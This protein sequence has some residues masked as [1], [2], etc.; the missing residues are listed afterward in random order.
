MTAKPPRPPPIQLRL[1]SLFILTAAVAGLFGLLRWLGVPPEASLIVLAVLT[2]GLVA[3]VGLVVV[4]A[5]SLGGEA[6]SEDA[7]KRKGADDGP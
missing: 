2:V 4:L 7:E 3:A 1:R 5:G 6:E